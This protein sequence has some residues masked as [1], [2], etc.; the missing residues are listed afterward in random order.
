MKGLLIKEMITNIKNNKF[1]LLIIPVFA[2]IGLLNKQNMFLM[3]IPV[4]LSILPLGQMSYDEMSHW[5]KYVYCMPVNKKT[6]VSSKYI[7]VVIMSV[8]SAVIIGLILLVAEHNTPNVFKEMLLMSAIAL[9]IGTF[10]PCIS[11]PINYKFGTTKGRIIYLIIV[12]I[13]CGVVPTTF[14]SNS[15]IL[16]EK[17]AKLLSEPVLFCAVS[18]GVLAVMLI[19]SWFIS[20]KI[21]E[22]KEA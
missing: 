20:I 8:F 18:I 11:L 5:D 7:T 3:I 21:Y 16:T 9:L 4:L 6:I 19:V 2:A 1:S 15:K 22:T 13:F 17:A 10:V 12:A 14:L